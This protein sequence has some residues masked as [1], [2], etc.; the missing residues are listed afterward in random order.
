MYICVHCYV[1]H[2]T[3]PPRSYRHTIA[4]L[5]PHER[6]ILLEVFSLIIRWLQTSMGRFSSA[7]YPRQHGRPA[8]V[9]DLLQPLAII[10]TV[11]LNFNH[12]WMKSLADYYL[13][14]PPIPNSTNTSHLS[15]N[16]A[17]GPGNLSITASS[18]CTL[19]DYR[20]SPRNAGHR[21]TPDPCMQHQ[22]LN[23]V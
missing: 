5:T 10:C 18:H 9:R 13:L 1:L 22:N 21:E 16:W 2:P 11:R 8:P 3:T 12:F 6:L 17:P 15:Q 14:R 19:S 20:G 23:N 4:L 7:T